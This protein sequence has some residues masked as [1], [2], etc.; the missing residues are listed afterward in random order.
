MKLV[1]LLPGTI[2][3]KG[4][5]IIKI[6][7][8]GRAGVKCSIYWAWNA[9]PRARD[10]GSL[11]RKNCKGKS[12]VAPSTRLPLTCSGSDL[13]AEAQGLLELRSRWWVCSL[14]RGTLAFL[15]YIVIASPLSL[16]PLLICLLLPS[17]LQH[18]W[19]HGG[20][21]KLRSGSPTSFP[22]KPQPDLHLRPRSLY[23]ISHLSLP[24]SACLILLLPGRLLC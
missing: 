6:N 1:C 12:R 24:L 11:L 13:G 17:S 23:S 16:R 9:I 15:A 22:S 10:K 18:H 2:F 7:G 20:L 8:L 19:V 3:D 5:R 4:M 21:G 14:L